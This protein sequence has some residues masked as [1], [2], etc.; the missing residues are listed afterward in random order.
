MKTN[1]FAANTMWRYMLVLFM[2]LAM[3]SLTYA[4]SKTIKGVVTDMQGEPVIGASVAVSGTT[5][6]T[7]TDINGEFTMT[8]APTDK[9]TISYIGY[10]KKEITVGERTNFTIQLNED[11]LLLDEVVVV[12]YGTQKKA[13]LTGAVSAISSK[14]ITVT[15]NENV[16]NMLAGK[17]PGVRIS[18][19]SSRP[20]AFDTNIDIRGMG[21]PLIVIDGVPRDKDYFSRMD[22]NEIESVSVLK[23]ASAAIYGLRS[24][25]GVIL[26]TTRRGTASASG[27]D[28]SYS[29]NYGWQQFLH[30]PNNVDAI[31]YMTLTNEQNWRDF[32]QNY[33]NRKT[34][35]YVD[36]DFDPYRNGT[37]QTTDWMKAVFKNTVPQQQHNV[38]VNG[39]TE[40]ISYFLNLGYMQQDGALRTGSMDYDRWNFRANIDAN[41]TKRLKTQLS[42][43]GYMDEMNEPRTDI[44]AVYKSAW[45]QKPIADLYANNNPD[46]L[47]NYLVT[48]G[49]PLATTNSDITGYRKNIN[50]VFNGQFAISY[51]IPGIEGLTAK[52]MYNYDFKY[53]DQ[54]DYKKLYYL[55]DY[56][57]ETEQY[58]PTTLNT[59]SSS[60]RRSSYP[61]YKTLMQLSLNYRRSFF[62]THNV[63]AVML[64]E[65]EYSSWD[66]FYA[67]REIYVNSEYLFAGENEKQEGYMD[68]NGLGD[69]SAK[70]WIG[71]FNYDY[72]GKYLA[73]FSFR[74]D[75]SSKFPKDERWGFFPAASVG[76]RISEESFIKEN[77]SFVNNVKLRGSYGKMGDDRDAS[78]YPPNIVGYEIDGGDRGWIYNGN[79]VAGTK[80]TAIPNP[81]LT[82]YTSKTL[83]IGIDVDL[84]NGLLGGSFDVYQRD[85]D[86]L[87]AERGALIP[88]TVGASL[89]KE[90][91]ESDRTSGFEI[92]LNH[93]NKIGDV[94]YFVTGQLSSTRNKWRTKVEE[95]AGNSYDNWRNRVDGRYKDIWWGYKYG[96]QF[97][98][99]EQI[100]YHAV[101]VGAGG[102]V[103][104]DYY[105]VDW[106]GDGVINDKD[107]YPIAT[108]GMP[109]FNYGFTLGADWKGI[110]LSMHFQGASDVYVQY[111]EALA[112]PLSFDGA[113]T[114]DK[115]WDRWHPVDPSADMFDPSTQ[116]V[117]GYYPTTGSPLA[118]GTRAIENASYLRM[119][120]IELGYSIPKKYL[121]KLW[122]KDLRIYF[123]G[124][125]LLTFTGLKNMDPEHPGGAG[126]NESD[127]DKG[128]WTI[129]NYKYPV[130]KTFN[131]GAS[132]KF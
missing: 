109:L 113:G 58:T 124:Y 3:P 55:Y 65:E 27:F 31:Q 92:V 39:G 116:W 64:Y 71:K 47:N 36:A 86:G 102:A 69:R 82:W 61:D 96:G 84:W 81:N 54:T 97:Q 103:P 62:E 56:N 87:L 1:A 5:N 105:Y 93:R 76:W 59:P 51:D 17:L 117:S 45:L 41:I 73:E 88:G 115:F 40:K 46:Y 128:G 121:S 52:A 13:T 29:M 60:V 98:N 7:A 50:R 119:K 63:S 42:L 43:G 129:D 126:A 37:K 130:N 44:W 89:P 26:V 77:L 131:I 34:P 127:R 10:E 67:F 30:V 80:P 91:L 68:K 107:K 72:K 106:N 120:T 8:V 132:I 16:T 118:E 111:S 28:I 11:N 123:S 101:S 110:D 104:G 12:G 108:Y 85:R 24:A 125:N 22:A 32:N 100:Y 49:N 19:T 94:S 83:D 114:M 74:Y 14:D 70:A 18:Q 53:A 9:L 90:N 20:G 112:Q 48:D 21:E 78:N 99:Y 122:I 66:N 33:M 75:G 35:I 15:K 6:G 95:K 79:L 57:P 38:T 2:S 25:N 23:D 4:Q